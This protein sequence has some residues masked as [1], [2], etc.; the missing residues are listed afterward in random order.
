MN[1]GNIKSSLIAYIFGTVLTIYTYSFYFIL[2]KIGHYDAALNITF[3]FFLIFIM[4]STYFFQN[5]FKRYITIERNVLVILS[6]WFLVT[7]VGYW[8]IKLFF[9]NPDYYPFLS[10]NFFYLTLII[11][12]VSLVRSDAINKM[13]VSIYIIY[14]IYGLYLIPT[15]YEAKVLGVYPPINKNVVGFFLLPLLAFIFM[16]LQK[17][18]KWMVIWYI[19]GAIILYLT[20][21]RTS[22]VSFLMLPIFIIFIKILKNKIRLFYLIYL[23]LGLTAVLVATYVIYPVYDKINY[24]FTDRILLWETYINYL[25]SSR[26]L[27]FGTGYHTLPE[28]MQG[29]GQPATI[30]PH[31]QFIMI[32]V[33]NGLIGLVFFMSFFLLSMP[34]YVGELLPSDGVLFVLITIQFSEAIIPLV[35]FSFLSFVFI[36]NV[37]INKSLH[38]DN[39]KEIY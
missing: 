5:D 10:R 32:L 9:E 14:F 26:S 12:F 27:L 23:F 33:M 15:L 25:V 13:L 35:D 7:F 29:I 24:L 31:N 36:V 37:L 28:L 34:K 18:I 3:M 22:F 38:N 2:P 1:Q 21:A 20:G 17:N 30:H 4:F 8:L 39:F 19:I 11:L 16:R 6:L